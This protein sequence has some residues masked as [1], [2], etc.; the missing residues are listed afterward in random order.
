[1]AHRLQAGPELRLGLADALG[2]GADLAVLGGVEHDDA[3]RL[4]QLVRAQHDAGVAVQL[5]HGAP[6]IGPTRSGPVVE[7]T[8]AALTASEVGD[9]FEQVVG[10]QLVPGHGMEHELAVRQLPHE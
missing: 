3:I 6:T 8:E 5:A 1:M 9:G 10:R 7:T 4:A 2:D